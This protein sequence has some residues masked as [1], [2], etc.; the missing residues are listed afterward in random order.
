MK[1]EIIDMAQNIFN[2]PY[3]DMILLMR[4][5]Y[6]N[7]IDL[8]VQKNSHNDIHEGKKDYILKVYNYYRD[9]K[10]LNSLSVYCDNQPVYEKEEGSKP[11]L[12][13]RE[14]IFADIKNM[15]DVLE[16]NFFV[17]VHQLEDD[18]PSVDRR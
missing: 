1:L 17:G 12:R 2:L 16:N 9:M 18:R 15:V 5:E 14:D 7:I 3:P 8:L 13:T 6:E 4:M 10:L 11:E